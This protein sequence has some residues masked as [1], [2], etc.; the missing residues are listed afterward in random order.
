MDFSLLVNAFDND[1]HLDL[2]VLLFTYKHVVNKKEGL[3]IKR[4]R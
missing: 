1:F 4:L 3:L 2:N